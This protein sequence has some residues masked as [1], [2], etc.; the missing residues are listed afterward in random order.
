[1]PKPAPNPRAIATNLAARSVFD[2]ANSRTPMPDADSPGDDTDDEA[3]SDKP[4]AGAKPVATPTRTRSR[5]A[6]DPLAIEIRKGVPMPPSTT[7]KDAGTPLLQLLQRLQPGD[8][9]VVSHK[10]GKALLNAGRRAKIP[11]ATRL[12]SDTEMGVWRL[13]G[14]KA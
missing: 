5:E 12:L 6:F 10:L 8:S 13:E 7:G 4:E 11:V 1:M 14:K 3:G 9:V 2:L